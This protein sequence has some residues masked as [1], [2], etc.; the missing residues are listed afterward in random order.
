MAMEGFGPF[1][2]ILG[3]WIRVLEVGGRHVGGQFHTRQPSLSLP[4]PQSRGLLLLGVLGCF[5]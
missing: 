2:W 1:G 3:L 4:P 5:G